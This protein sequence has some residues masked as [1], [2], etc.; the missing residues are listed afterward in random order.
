M[1]DNLPDLT[2]ALG[3]AVSLFT[4][5]MSVQYPRIQETFDKG[6]DDL[7]KAKNPV[8]RRKREIRG[9]LLGSALPLGLASYFLAYL[10]GWALLIQAGGW[11]VERGVTGLATA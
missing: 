2:S 4:F 10:S 11:S 8:K 9:V 7:A 6:T 5:A 3:L 1:N